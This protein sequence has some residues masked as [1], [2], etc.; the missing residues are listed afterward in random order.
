[1]SQTNFDV[2]CYSEILKFISEKNKTI[3]PDKISL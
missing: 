1:M 2:I 3:I